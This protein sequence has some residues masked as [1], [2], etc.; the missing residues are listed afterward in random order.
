VRAKIGSIY[1]AYFKPNAQRRSN[2][3]AVMKSPSQLAL[4][5]ARAESADCGSPIQAEF[6]DSQMKSPADCRH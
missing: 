4:L 1:D 3:L 5:L 6:D 2:E